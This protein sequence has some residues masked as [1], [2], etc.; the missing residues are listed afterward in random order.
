MI[1][2]IH[3]HTLPT[4][5]LY[6]F[7]LLLFSCR[8]T[9]YLT[10]IEASKQNVSIEA[11][12][13]EDTAINALIQP[14]KKKLDAQMNQTIGHTSVDLKKK[15]PESTLGNWMA[16]AIQRQAEKQLGHPIAFAIQNQGGI[17]ISEI[18]KGPISKG[19]IFELMPFDNVVVILSLDSIEVQELAQ[20]IVQSGGW[21]ISHS[22]KIKQDSTEN[23]EIF[24]HGKPLNGDSAYQVALPDYVANGGSDSGFLKGKP[25]R[26]LDLFIRDALIND[27][28]EFT[29]EGKVIESTIEGR[30]VLFH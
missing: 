28:E 5:I 18:S 11:A 4:T 23:L 6:C 25:Q 13:T 27:L 22:L 1:P 3:K 30:L 9:N 14:Y 10:S 17:R 24:I 8:S 29:A 2:T 21:P 7:L 12:P 19:K 15:R 20:H 16:D 26:K